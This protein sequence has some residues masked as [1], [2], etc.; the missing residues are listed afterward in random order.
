MTKVKHRPLFPPSS[1]RS[2]QFGWI[3]LNETYLDISPMRYFD[4]IEHAHT[5]SGP[6]A[7]KPEPPRS[8][9]LTNDVDDRG[10]AGKFGT[11]VELPDI[12]SV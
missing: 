5:I 4:L 2:Y 1:N 7:S 3:V 12:D 9:I 10:L 8:L 11:G 6:K